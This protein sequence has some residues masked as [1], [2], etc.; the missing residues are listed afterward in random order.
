VQK[1]AGSAAIAGNAAQ[2]MTPEQIGL[3]P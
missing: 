2:R 1:V 3:E